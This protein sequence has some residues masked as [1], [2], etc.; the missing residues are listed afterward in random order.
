M[1]PFSDLGRVYFIFF[2]KSGGLSGDFI[3]RL[4]THIIAEGIAATACH[5][6]RNPVSHYNLIPIT[7]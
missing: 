5:R 1:T 3:D 7:Q 2:L 4:Q 6:K